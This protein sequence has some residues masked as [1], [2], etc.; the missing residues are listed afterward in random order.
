MNNSLDYTQD[1]LREFYLKEDTRVR[2]EPWYIEEPE[3]DARIRDTSLCDICKYIDFEYLLK[4]KVKMYH[5]PILLV[6]DMIASRERCS[7]CKLAL[8]TMSTADDV[9]AVVEESMSS[10]YWQIIIP[11][12]RTFL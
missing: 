3:T 4:N 5:G 7:F 6:K 9:E 1:D 2:D 8:I 12:A 10:A 11:S